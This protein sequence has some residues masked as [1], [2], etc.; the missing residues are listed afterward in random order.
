MKNARI[1]SRVVLNILMLCIFFFSA[2]HHNSTIVTFPYF[3]F[4]LAI[5][6]FVIYVIKQLLRSSLESASDGL[7]HRLIMNS[8]LALLYLVQFIFMIVINSESPTYYRDD[9]LISMYMSYQ[10]VIVLYFLFLAVYIYSMIYNYVIDNKCVSKGLTEEVFSKKHYTLNAVIF[11]LCV[12]LL[13]CFYT[14]LFQYLLVSVIGIS[15]EAGSTNILLAI[16]GLI[17]V[18]CVLFGTLYIVLAS[19]LIVI[20]LPLFVYIAYLGVR[21]ENVK[22]IS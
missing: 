21:K 2:F 8:V 9:S 16:I 15:F 22:S 11:V 6:V 12:I 1:H 5:H 7:K 17:L 14:V 13:I 10:T 19:Y 3:I 18:I 20:I 4:M